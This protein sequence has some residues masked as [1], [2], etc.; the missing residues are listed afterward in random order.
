MKKMKSKAV[1]SRFFSGASTTRPPFLPIVCRMAARLEMISI[2]EMFNSPDLLSRCIL[3]AQKLYGY[4]GVVN[5]FDPTLEAE[6]CGAGIEWGGEYDLPSV[7]RPVPVEEIQGNKIDLSSIGER[8]RIPV[9]IEATKRMKTLIGKSVAVMGVVTGPMSIAANLTGMDLVHK[10]EED[11]Q[12]LGPVLDFA[13]RIMLQVSRL[14]CELDVDIILVI[15]DIMAGL[16]PEV[17]RGLEPYIG[18]V[19]NV[20]SFFSAPSVFLA[21]GC[22]DIA[23]FEAVK[24]MGADSTVLR[25]DACTLDRG[26]P[27]IGLGISLSELQDKEKDVERFLADIV[28]ERKPGSFFLTTDWDVSP[29]I[30][31]ERLY[32]LMQRFRR[33]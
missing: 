22:S 7:A 4:D 10:N 13:S 5:I 28:R 24:G 16:K 3:N 17:M 30:P 2:R 14:Y 31:S 20:A 26:E 27:C 15:D 29:D 18:P 23:G 11:L 6:A 9:V 21:K 19:W 25:V 33:V 1:V 32:D 8:G 12:E